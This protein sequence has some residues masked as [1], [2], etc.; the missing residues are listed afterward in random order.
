MLAP[1]FY[2][3]RIKDD[4]TRPFW[5]NITDFGQVLDW[6]SGAYAVVRV[7]PL[8]RGETAV[9]SKG[10]IQIWPQSKLVSQA[11]GGACLITHFVEFEEL[12]RQLNTKLTAG[13]I[14]VCGRE[15][16]GSMIMTIKNSVAVAVK[17]A[18]GPSA[19]PASVQMEIFH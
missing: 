15:H 11:F 8:I 5:Q 17:E 19:E 2:F 16:G 6:S 10:H 7:F 4:N 14:A 13:G 1:N 12:L 18:P 3:M 9:D